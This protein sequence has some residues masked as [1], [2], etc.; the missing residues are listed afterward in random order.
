MTVTLYEIVKEENGIL[1]PDYDFGNWSEFEK[2]V[3][4]PFIS[5]MS[6]EKRRGEN[7]KKVIHSFVIDKSLEYFEDYL[8]RAVNFMETNSLTK[9][10]WNKEKIEE[11]IKGSGLKYYSIPEAIKLIRKVRDLSNGDYLL[12]DIKGINEDLMNIYY[13]FGEK[14]K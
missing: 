2:K 9:L 11:N 1:V 8:K 5:F 4:K 14:Q 13:K 12:L 10:N 7:I 3:E 6:F